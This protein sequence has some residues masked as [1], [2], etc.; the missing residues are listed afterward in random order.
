MKY[1]STA[2]ALPFVRSANNYDTMAV[3]NETGLKC[4][5][6][7]LAQQ[8]AKDECDI[9]IILQKMANGIMPDATARTPQFGDFTTTANDYH[10]ALNMV[11]A[12][13]ESF[14]SLPA[15]IRARFDNDPEKLLAFVQDEKNL[16]EAVK[17]GLATAPREDL[18]TVPDPAIK[19]G[20]GSGAVEKSGKLGRMREI[21]SSLPKGFKIVPDDIGGDE[22]DD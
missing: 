18:S 22:G 9:N 12:A 10:N 16:D 6:V 11:I 14:D 20:K 3:S 2:P 13:Q 21:A 4:E 7:S 15:N 5:D 8:N 17:L 1:E 19:G